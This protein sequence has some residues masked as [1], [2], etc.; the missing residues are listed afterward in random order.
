MK[1]QPNNP[2]LT[3]MPF[4]PSGK[5]TGFSG[6]GVSASFESTKAT[7]EHEDHVALRE[8]QEKNPVGIRVLRI[9]GN[10]MRR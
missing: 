7:D 6:A 8:S 4:E 3:Q 1:P 10:D 2:S 9:A 5:T